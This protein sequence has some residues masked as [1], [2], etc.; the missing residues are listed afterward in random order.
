G[1]EPRRI[2]PF[3]RAGAADPGQP[4]V[5]SEA[6]LCDAGRHRGAARDQA[7]AG[8]ALRRADP[9]GAAGMDRAAAGRRSAPSLSADRAR[10]R[11]LAGAARRPGGLH[12]RRARQAGAVV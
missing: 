12:E 10:H 8:H 11:R 6:R 3:L 4:R 7:G 2:G 1:D 9:A 5:R